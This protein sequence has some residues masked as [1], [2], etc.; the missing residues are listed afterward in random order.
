MNVLITLGK[1]IQ[2]VREKQGLTQEQLEEKTDVNT[3]YISA[4]ERG[5]KNVTVNTLMKIAA[6]LNVEVYE[7]FLL[8]EEIGSERAFKKAI[9][10]LLKEADTKS[11]KL[12]LEFLRKAVG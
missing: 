11:L 6:G 5:K 9:E 4:I 2:S 8:S 7:L 1:R 10:S 3:K 12:C